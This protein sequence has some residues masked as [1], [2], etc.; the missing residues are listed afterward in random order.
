MI[1]DGQTNF[2]VTLQTVSVNQQL[3]PHTLFVVSDDFRSLFTLSDFVGDNNL[4]YNK[5]FTLFEYLNETHFITVRFITNLKLTL[6]LGD[7]KSLTY[8]LPMMILK[9]S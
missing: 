3:K 9:K 4:H 8:H 2:R 5:T 1:V 6:L 7:W